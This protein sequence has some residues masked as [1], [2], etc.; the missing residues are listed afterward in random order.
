MKIKP[1]IKL[2]RYS[3]YNETNLNSSLIMPVFFFSDDTLICYGIYG[4]FSVVSPW[5]DTS[6][7]VTNFPEY[8]AKVSPK[9]CLHTRY[10]RDYCQYL[11]HENRS[12]VYRSYFTPFHKTYVLTHGFLE[13][14]EKPWL[15]VS[16]CILP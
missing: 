3:S 7:P 16:Y 11:D 13:N 10:N 8:P 5:I 15:K 9:Y 4:C 12:S 1:F 2:N 6:R 14:G